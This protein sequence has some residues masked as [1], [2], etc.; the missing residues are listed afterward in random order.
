MT[1]ERLRFRE[2]MLAIRLKYLVRL[3]LA[4]W[5]LALFMVGCFIV[6]A[7]V[8]VD[9]GPVPRSFEARLLFVLT[10]CVIT[11]VLAAC[12]RLFVTLTMP[13][14]RRAFVDARCKTDIALIYELALQAEKPHPQPRAE[15]SLCDGIE[16]P[17]SLVI[18]DFDGT[19]ANSA[20]WFFSVFNEV[21]EKH[22]FRRVSEK[23]GQALRSKSTAQI[24][25]HLGIP[26]WRLPL[27]ARDMRRRNALADIA[28][29]E[30]MAQI[31]ESLV[32]RGIHVAIASS[33]SETN[34]RKVLGRTADNIAYFSCGASLFGKSRHFR[35]LMRSYDPRGVLC[36]GD[37]TR[38]IG[39]AR[40]VNIRCIGVTWGYAS[41][42]ALSA[43]RPDHLVHS[44]AELGAL[45]GTFT[46]IPLAPFIAPLRP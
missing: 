38:D 10:A 3:I 44:V 42:S 14:A 17:L 13:R 37:E 16:K 6:I 18:L 26:Q 25:A 22:G 27:I 30:G 46:P 8:A 45:L 33:N 39:A 2:A 29:F 32:A 7:F 34:I 23:E 1:P 31:I 40:A 15:V 35:R 12:I 24:L 11:P 43:E 4:Q 28:L 5:P 41:A 9:D 20:P 19:I 36:I 21:A